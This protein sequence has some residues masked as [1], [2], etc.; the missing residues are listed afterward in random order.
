MDRD[1]GMDQHMIYDHG[2]GFKIRHKHVRTHERQ[3]SIAAQMKLT[4]AD[5]DS[6]REVRDMGLH[7]RLAQN[8]TDLSMKILD[9]HRPMYYIGHAF[10]ILWLD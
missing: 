10:C 4:L 8:R 5:A 7:R 9:A 2:L 1:H 3:H 6:A